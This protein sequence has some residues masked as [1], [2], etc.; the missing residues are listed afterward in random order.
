ML[1]FAY[2]SC[3]GWYKVNPFKF[4]RKI[5]WVKK[6]T[7]IQI[8]NFLGVKSKFCLPQ[9]TFWSFQISE[10]L[11]QTLMVTPVR[12]RKILE[13]WHS[14][15]CSKTHFLNQVYRR[16]QTPN[17]F[18]IAQEWPWVFALNPPRFGI[19][20]R[21]SGGGEDG[22]LI[23]PLENSEFVFLYFFLLRGFSF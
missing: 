4:K 8:P 13:F 16:F 18:W 21:S 7:K 11:A 2:F 5:L 10:D 12:F 15:N 19:F 9:R 3:I 17:F 22:I 6:N 23:W 1:I 14:Q 20:K